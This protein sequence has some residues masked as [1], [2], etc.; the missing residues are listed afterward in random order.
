MLSKL[1]W[2]AKPT[3][4]TVGDG[5][6]KVVPKEVMEFLSG[7]ILQGIRDLGRGHSPKH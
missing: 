6:L 3:F 7:W 4:C 1:K 5:S 2:E